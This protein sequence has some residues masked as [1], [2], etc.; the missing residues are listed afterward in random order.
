MNKKVL[1][2]ILCIIFVSVPVSS[3]AGII[4][5]F[6]TTK[7]ENGT[8]IPNILKKQTNHLILQPDNDWDYWSNPPNMFSMKSGNVG[9]GTSNPSAK[10]DIEVSSGGIATIGS[11]NTVA[12]GNFSIAM[13]YGTNASG[14]Y[15]TAMGKYSHASG[16]TST[17]MGWGTTASG[18]CSTAMGED[19]TAGGAFSTAIGRSIHV[20]GDYSVGIGLDDTVSMVTLDHVMAIMG[21]KVGIGTTNP[22]KL[23]EVSG[24]QDVVAQ[25]SGRVKGADAVN[26]D[27]FVTKGQVKSVSTFNYTPTG[28]SDPNGN[29]GDTAWDDYYFYVKTP[30]GWKRVQLETWEPTPLQISTTLNK[31]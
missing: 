20:N 21:G 15:S 5:S 17:A 4:N 31:K 3:V 1:V 19:T 28:T 23:L 9:I 10:L 14:R 18:S 11:L 26:D 6:K 27:E 8:F 30:D 24:N 25:F 29:V 12:L 2:I 22:S 13:G 16:P 7:V